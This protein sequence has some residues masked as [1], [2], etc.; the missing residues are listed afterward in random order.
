[1][2]ARQI[3]TIAGPHLASAAETLALLERKPAFQTT[4][5]RAGIDL[6][7]LRGFFG[8]LSHLLRDRGGPPDSGGTSVEA[9]PEPPATD[10]EES[11]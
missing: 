5:R 9:S 11:E 2:L 10:E 1:M 3:Q 6:D 7:E 8:D 4:A